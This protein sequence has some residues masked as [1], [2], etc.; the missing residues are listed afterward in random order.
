[1]TS[2]IK[3]IEHILLVQ[4]FQRIHIPQTRAT[5]QRIQSNVREVIYCKNRVKFKPNL[6]RS[7]TKTKSIINV[8]RYKLIQ[9][10][11]K[12]N[13]VCQFIVAPSQNH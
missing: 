8:V 1:M 9:K 13:K 4:Q 12:S 2:E 10:P 7:Q 6:S 3:R 5:R 11:T